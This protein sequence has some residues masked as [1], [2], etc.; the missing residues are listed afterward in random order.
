[1]QEY[2]YLRATLGAID[3]KSYRC[4]ECVNQFRGRTDSATMLERA[5]K[6]KG[7]TKEYAAPVH[8]IDDIGFTLCP[9]NF[10]SKSAEGLIEAYYFFERGILPYPGSLMDQPNKIIEIFRVIEAYKNDKIL[11]ETKKQGSSNKWP[12]TKSRS[13]R[14][15]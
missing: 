12:T 1:M 8:R 7:C 5:K 11:K 3:N 15:L 14:K 13:S 4:H 2:A 6:T 10:Y 9:G